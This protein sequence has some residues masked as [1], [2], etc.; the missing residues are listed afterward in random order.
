MTEAMFHLGTRQPLFGL[1]VNALTMEQVLQE[2]ALHAADRSRFLIGVV[3]AA[4]IVKLRKDPLLRDSLLVP[5]V[6]L[7][8]GQSV[9]W[10]SR[11]LGHPLP[12]R[13]A[14][15]DLFERLLALA[16]EDHRSVYFLG[17]KHEVLEAMVERVQARY[18]GLVVAGY[19]DGY[20]AVDDSAEVAT[21]IAATGADMLFLGITSP[22]KEIFLARHGDHLGVP[23]LHGVG[24][25]FDILAGVTKRAPERWQRLGLEWAYR[26]LQE[27]RRL[28][29]RYASTNSVFIALTIRERFR[30]TRTYELSAPPGAPTDR[31]S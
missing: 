8:D 4:K 6:L 23:I 16:D 19:R 17:A 9:V 3:N 12:E 13:V 20:F 30:P 15:I 1:R 14:G 25:S 18:P 10:A 27:P 26:L 24:G 7:A 2:A 29:A 31:K 5:D 22:K 11:L 21:E 28:F